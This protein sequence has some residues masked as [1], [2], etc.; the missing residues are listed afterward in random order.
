MGSEPQPMHDDIIR[1]PTLIN[2]FT[3]LFQIWSHK[4]CGNSVMGA[5]YPHPLHIMFVNPP[6]MFGVD[7]GAIQCGFRAR[8]NA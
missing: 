5:P 3:C 7:V 4:C 1:H 8:T 2:D 6:Y